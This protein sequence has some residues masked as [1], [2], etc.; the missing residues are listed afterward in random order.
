MST[1]GSTVAA[2]AAQRA[3]SGRLA[4]R[5]ALLY[6]A[7]SAAWI[8]A[9][10]QVLAVFTGASATFSLG[11]T[12]KGLGFVSVSAGFLFLLVRRGY[13]RLQQ[14]DYELAAA[15]A[16]VDALLAHGLREQLPIAVWTTDRDL[17][18]TASEGSLARR[19]GGEKTLVGQ[20]IGDSIEVGRDESVS[21]HEA[22][23]AG[24]PSSYTRTAFGLRLEAHIEPLRDPTSGDI[25]GVV[26]LALDVTEREQQEARLRQ[27]AKLE[28]V[29]RLAGGVAHDFNNLLTGILGFLGFALRSLGRHPARHDLEQAERAARR[30][31]A[32]TQQ[33]LTFARRD[34][35]DAEPLDLGA[36]V[37]QLLPLLDELA[38]PGIPV[39]LEETDLCWAAIH[40]LPLEQVVVNLVA[41]ARDAQ[42]RGGRIRIRTASEEVDG[43]RWAAI[44]VADEGHGLSA[45]TR[46]H[47][48]EP[49]FTTKP[50]GQG[51]GLGLA[52]S[53]AAVEDVGGRID[54]ASEP[55]RGSTFTVLLPCVDPPTATSPA[56][57]GTQPAA[58]GGRRVLVVEDEE[59]LRELFRRWLVDAGHEVEVAPD[60]AAARTLLAAGAYDAVVSDV[61]LPDGSGTDVAALAQ[62]PGR[63]VVLMSGRALPPE[64]VPEGATTLAKPFGRD[65]LVRAVS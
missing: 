3:R 25:V 5:L 26:G 2:V 32:L 13:R 33:L 20:R 40:P 47:L 50:V 54:V 8:V 49:F 55:G 41:N 4:L 23:L 44:H 27:A 38:G 43:T 18:I 65:E 9:S 53:L 58:A 12:A 11:Q 45:E 51:T 46:E 22:A 48:F 39:E 34:D 6:F 16:R 64:L 29:G 1:P 37:R 28:A 24:E 42:A 14:S 56:T 31:A 60:A 10:D 63:T 36:T 59:A 57:D 17:R 35:G 62:A 52:T 7:V 61:T 19:I 21:L 15:H 30:A